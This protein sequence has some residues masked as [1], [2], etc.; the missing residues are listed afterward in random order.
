[1]TVGSVEAEV[2]TAVS[3][4][5]EVAVLLE[6]VTVAVTPGVGMEVVRVWP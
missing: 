2:M 1:M 6:E 5:V 4:E 3:V